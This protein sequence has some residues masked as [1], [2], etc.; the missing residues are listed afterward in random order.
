MCKQHGS[1]DSGPYKVADKMSATFYFRQSGCNRHISG[2]NEEIKTAKRRF[3]SQILVGGFDFRESG[4][5]KDATR[6]ILREPVT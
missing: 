6:P 5:P 3:D 1:Y 2:L 4:F